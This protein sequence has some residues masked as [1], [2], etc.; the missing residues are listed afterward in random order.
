[1]A[2]YYWVLCVIGYFILWLFTAW[3]LKYIFWYYDV[4]ERGCIAIIWPVIWVILILFL[5]F[6]LITFI[7]E[8]LE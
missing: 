6:A 8:K 4:D 5:P 7:L 2:W 1:M 3:I